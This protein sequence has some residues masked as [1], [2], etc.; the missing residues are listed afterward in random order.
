MLQ[1]LPS[2]FCASAAF[3]IASCLSCAPGTADDD[4]RV[5][6]L[7]VAFVYNF[8]KFT[9]WPEPQDQ[10]SPK[11]HFCFSPGSIDQKLQESLASNLV[12]GRS[13]EIQ[14][15]RNNFSPCHVIYVGRDS[16]N[17]FLNEAIKWGRRRP[18]LLVSDIEGFAHRGGH[19][20]LYTVGNNLRFRVNLASV[21]ESNLKLSSKLLNLADVVSGKEQ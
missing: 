12:N 16:K 3:F 17:G 7:K 15:V 18:V 11:I 6:A 13:I 9:E 5:S 2:I 21:R 20:E 4:L 1:R 8:A 10:R 14:E 19:I